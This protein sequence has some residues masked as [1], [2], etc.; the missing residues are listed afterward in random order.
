MLPGAIVLPMMPGVEK[1]ESNFR[2]LART[3]KR[4]QPHTVVARGPFAANLAIR[5]RNK[6]LVGR[7]VFDGRGA[8]A[9]EFNEYNVAQSAKLNREIRTIESHAVVKSDFRIAV[10]EALVKYWRR[11]SAYPGNQHV[12]IPCTLRKLEQETIDAVASVRNRFGFTEDDIII[13]YAGS[14]AGWQSFDLMNR[15]MPGLF[16]QNTKVKLLVLTENTDGLQLLQ[17]FP[18][19]V[20][21]SWLKANEVNSVL[22]ACDYGWLVREQSVTN[23]VASPVKFAEYLAAGIPIII[24]EQLGDFTGFVRQHGCG[25]VLEEGGTNQLRRISA[26]EVSRNRTLAMQHFTKQAFSE[27]YRQIAG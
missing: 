24:S 17:K 1:W 19:R 26:A 5:A 13:A 25:F 4:Y 16:S 20:K 14:A 27:H 7:V 11:E 21:V 18:D 9:A 22:S 3:L 10:S 15:Y 23:E 6:K 8:Y 12:V 2:L